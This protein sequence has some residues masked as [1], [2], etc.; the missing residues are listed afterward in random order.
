MPYPA[1]HAFMVM[2]YSAPHAFMVMPYSAPSVL[3]VISM[4]HPPDFMIMPYQPDLKTQ[5]Y[6]YEINLP[7]LLSVI[8]LPSTAI[9]PPTIT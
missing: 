3:T 2:P 5:N 9:F 8:L 7:S 4:S 1:P 6:L